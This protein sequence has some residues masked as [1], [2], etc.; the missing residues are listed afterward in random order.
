MTLGPVSRLLTRYERGL[1]RKPVSL[2][3]VAGIGAAGGNPDVGYWTFVL[4]AETRLWWPGR[5]LFDTYVTSAPVGPFASV[6]V[7]V[8]WLRVTAFGETLDPIFHVSFSAGPGYRLSLFGRF[9]ITLMAQCSL[10][11][12]IGDAEGAEGAGLPPGVLLRS[13]RSGFF[14]GARLDER[15]RVGLTLSLAL[16]TLF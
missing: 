15:T 13:S 12:E 3:G 16:E 4:G 7:E 9:G 2:G 14:G 1:R 5:G 8:D 11:H 10:V 6:R